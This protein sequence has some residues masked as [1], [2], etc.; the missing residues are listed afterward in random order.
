[1][2][3]SSPK[4]LES[5]VKAFN[6]QEDDKVLQEAPRF[7]SSQNPEVASTARRLMAAVC[8]F[9]QK[10]SE[11]KEQYLEV[12]KFSC[13]VPMDHLSVVTSAAMAKDYE[14][15][16]RY[17]LVA[18]K[19]IAKA[20]KEG[21][22][23]WSPLNPEKVS[24]AYLYYYYGQALCDSG[25]CEKAFSPLSRLSDIYTELKITDD[26]FLIMR[27]V[28]YFGEFLM[29]LGKVKSG[30]PQ[31]TDWKAFHKKL[32]EVLDEEGKVQ[33]AGVFS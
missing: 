2:S 11:A 9:G 15:A 30:A 32:S 22:L 1:M 29:L 4:E 25:A 10:Y 23:V 16:E 13:C 5:L 18:E 12:V 28:P 6:Q 26:H 7:F 14:T 8:F 27:A 19:E 20:L 31:V 33:L 21:S 24:V 17:V 3:L